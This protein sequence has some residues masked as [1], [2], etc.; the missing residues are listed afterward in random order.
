MPTTWPAFESAVRAH[1]TAQFTEVGSQILWENDLA[2]GQK[3]GTATPVNKPGAANSEWVRFSLALGDA[4]L[5]EI[6]GPGTPSEQTG[7]LQVQVFVPIG[8]GTSRLQDIANALGQ[9]LQR[10]RIGEA[11]FRELEVLGRG[12]TPDNR[13]FGVTL[14]VPFVFDHLP[15]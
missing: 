2:L 3:P 1:V 4:S 10:Q 12:A 14:S 6:G 9:V 11:H 8:S 7:R 5:Q 13:W 15:A